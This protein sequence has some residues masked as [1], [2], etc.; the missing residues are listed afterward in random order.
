[1]S[2]LPECRRAEVLRGIAGKIPCIHFCS[3]ETY[4]NA[5]DD[6]ISG[7]RRDGIDDIV[8]LSL[9]TETDSIVSGAVKNGV[10]GEIRFMSC[11]KFKGLEADAVILV[12]FTERTV[13]DDAMLFYST[14]S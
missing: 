12:D 10:Y 3:K 14:C 6:V 11:R 13:T 9:S 7:L 2:L 4:F 5:L 8:I 1:M